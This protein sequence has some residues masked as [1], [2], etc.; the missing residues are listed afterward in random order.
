MSDLKLSIAVLVSYVTVVLGIA[1]IDVFQETV[2]DFDPIFFLLVAL[3]VFSELVVIGNLIKAGV[4]ISYYMVISFWVGVYL[5]LWIFF[6]GNSRPIQVQIIQLLLVA[7]SA[8]LAYDVGK[9][10]GQVDKTLEGL[11]TGTYPNR[12][13][14]LREARDLVDGEITRSRRY[15]H[16]LAVLAISLDGQGGASLEKPAYYETLEKD[17]IERLAL[18]KTG[19][20]LSNYARKTDLVLKDNDGLFILICPE[21]DMKNI[22]LLADRINTTVKDSLQVSIQWGGASFPDEAITF[23]DLIQA[24]KERLKKNSL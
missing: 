6:F 17:M 5:F 4:R 13:R 7:I 21:T 23:D 16:P 3:I 15:H 22:S 10:I 20:I 11:L 12:T 2:I 8:G 1:N 9:R 18:A 14:N 19:Q 24:A